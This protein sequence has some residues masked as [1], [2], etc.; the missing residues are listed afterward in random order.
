[1]F[2][3][4]SPRM[5]LLCCFCFC[6]TRSWSADSFFLRLPVGVLHPL[7]SAGVFNPL[8]EVGVAFCSEPGSSSSSNSRIEDEEAETAR[9]PLLL[10][11]TAIIL[12]FL[13]LLLLLSPS[14]GS[15]RCCCTS[16]TLASRP[17]LLPLLFNA[18]LEVEGEPLSDDE[19][20]CGVS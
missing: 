16:S 7:D 14:C 12:R 15:C 6:R 5:I 2:M 4:S 19:E 18:D 13:L 17:W 20:A 10:P 3:R 11:L 1:M 9:L 8:V